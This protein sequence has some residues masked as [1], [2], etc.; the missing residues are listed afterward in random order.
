MSRTTKAATT[1]KVPDGPKMLRETLCVAQHRIG[2]SPYDEGRKREHI[3]RLQRLI[4][5]CERHRPTGPNGKHGNRHTPT[6]GCEDQSAKP[7]VT[8]W[9]D[10]A[11]GWS[12]LLDHYLGKRP[13]SN[14]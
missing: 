11:K 3:D 4:D 14:R 6:C 9:R 8:F 12:T 13:Q 5:E 2:S 1:Y 7:W 10:V